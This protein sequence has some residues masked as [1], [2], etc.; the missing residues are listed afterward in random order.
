MDVQD[1]DE[2][3]EEAESLLAESVPKTPNIP[4]G[5]TLPRDGEESAAPNG[6]EAPPDEEDNAAES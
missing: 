4:T 6:E 5:K 2:L 3:E 1:A